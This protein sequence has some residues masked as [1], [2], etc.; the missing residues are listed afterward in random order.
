VAAK[1]ELTFDFRSSPIDIPTPIATVR[2]FT[3][4]GVAKW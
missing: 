2:S 4:G 3:F 1:R